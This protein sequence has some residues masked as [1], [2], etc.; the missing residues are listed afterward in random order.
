VFEVNYFGVVALTQKFLPLVRESKGRVINVSSG[1]GV[2]AIGA[3]SAYC[4]TKFALEGFT[5]S[6]RKEMLPLDVAVSLINPGV[7]KTKIID[8]HEVRIASTHLD[9]QAMSL[10]GRYYKN[11]LERTKSA[12]ASAPT[13]EVTT[14]AIL[15][16]TVAVSPKTRYYVSGAGPIPV[17]V[18]A[19]LARVLPTNL[20]DRLME[21]ATT[22]K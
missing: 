17:S 3:R 16:A 20:F 18:A 19:F 7:V 14:D 2:L 15:D 9:E 10:Y 8:K 11:E 12:F 6:L 13:T 5:D 22:A 1:F 4:S 21:A